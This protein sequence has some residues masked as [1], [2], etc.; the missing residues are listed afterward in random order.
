MTRKLEP[1][2]E[3]VLASASRKQIVASLLRLRPQIRSGKWLDASNRYLSNT[4]ANLAAD[5]Q[6]ASHIRDSDLSEYIAVSA[7]LHCIDGW[8]FLGRSIDCHAR[9]DADSARHLGYYAELRGAMSLLASEGI[10]VFNNL[11]FV[12]D[13]SGNCITLPKFSTKSK[14]Y[15]RTHLATWL[16]LE[17]WANLSSSSVLLPRI[18][19]AAGIPLEDWLIA[20]YGGSST[21]RTFGRE[22]LKSW[23]LDIRRFG[24]D[25]NAR[26]EA[27][28]RPTGLI[29]HGC[30]GAMDSMSL[31]RC[32]WYMACPSGFSRFQTLDRHLVRLSLHDAFI[33]Y[34]KGGVKVDKED[35]DRRVEKVLDILAIDGSDGVRWRDF[36]TRN[37]DRSNLPIIDEAAGVAPVGD[38]HHHAQVMSRAALLLRVAAGACAKLLLDAGLNRGD[39]RF[40]WETLGEDRGLWPPGA[41]PSDCSDLWADVEPALEDLVKWE[42]DNVGA[43]P[44]FFELRLDRPEALLAITG[45]ERI[46]LWGIGL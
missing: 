9:G 7:I 17:Y 44:S 3:K 23:G 11:H 33:P 45:C 21:S 10:G 14:V 35:F 29:R 25:R 30:L 2:Q 6:K 26:N 27:S 32:F 16:A 36:L 19:S 4:I 20:F 37:T 5:S 34:K 28:Y 38:P 40:W 24:D 46:A 13:S 42:D 43:T 8:S 18:V 39:L 31:V 41:A 15:P 1:P 22:R 12:V